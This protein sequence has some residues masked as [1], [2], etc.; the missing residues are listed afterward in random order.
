MKSESSNFYIVESLI[1]YKIENNEEFYLVKWEDYDLED[2]TWEPSDQVPA[3]L[4]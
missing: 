2:C 1:D 4:A 3:N